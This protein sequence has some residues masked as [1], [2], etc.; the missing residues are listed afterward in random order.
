MSC[1][2][3]TA[4]HGL[5]ITLVCF[6]GFLNCSTGALVLDQLWHSIT[7]GIAVLSVRMQGKQKVAMLSIP[8]L[9]H[10]VRDLYLEDVLERTNF[11]IGRGS[12]SVLLQSA[13]NLQYLSACLC[14]VSLPLIEQSY[15][16]CFPWLLVLFVS[17]HS[18]HEWPSWQHKEEQLCCAACQVLATLDRFTLGRACQ[19]ALQMGP[20]RDK[21]HRQGRQ[22]GCG[23]QLG[24]DKQCLQPKHAEQSGAG[25]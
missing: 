24:G 17:C 19:C 12:K 5:Q 6:H 15:L 10:P 22:C 9:T 3:C 23:K 1:C 11:I 7:W 14:P 18:T 16:S 25:S 8:G 21:R 13:V 20:Q 4:R 2:L